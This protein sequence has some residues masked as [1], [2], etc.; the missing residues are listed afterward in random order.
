MPSSI[1]SAAPRYFTDLAFGNG[2]AIV[3]TICRT[4][5]HSDSY[6]Y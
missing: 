6:R 2:N 5:E 4:A 3:D 1:P